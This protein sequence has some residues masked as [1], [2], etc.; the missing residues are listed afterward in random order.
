MAHTIHI[1]VNASLKDSDLIFRILNFKEDIHREILRRDCGVVANP[2]SVDQALAPVTITIARK[3]QFEH[4]SSFIAGRLDHH[5][6]AEAVR[7]ST[8]D[9]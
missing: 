9:S 2:A 5:S 7:I 3:R 6:V 4:L 1:A 8:E